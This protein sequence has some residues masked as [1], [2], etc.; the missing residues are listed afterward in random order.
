MNLI[1]H[2]LIFKSLSQKKTSLQKFNLVRVLFLPFLCF[3]FLDVK[4]VAAHVQQSQSSILYTG[5]SGNLTIGDHL[6][7]LE[8]KAGSLGI[9][10]V[11]SSGDFIRSKKNVPNLGVSNSVFWIKFKVHNQSEIENL[12]LE[13]GYPLLDQ[14]HFYSI[15]EEGKYDI[16]KAGEYLPFGS[17]KYNYQTFLFDLKI[18]HGETREYYMQVSSG[19]QIL[20]PA[21][22]GSYQAIAESH[23][24]RDIL[25]GIYFGIILVMMLYN[26]FIYFTVKDKSYLWYVIYIFFVGLT[27]SILQGYAYKYFWPSNPWVAMHSTYLVG[28]AVGLATLMFFRSFL[29]TKENA[30]G[31]HKALHI[32]AV[33]YCLCIVLALFGFY[34]ESYRL[35]DL[36]AG[37]GSLFLLFIA[38][39]IYQ[40]G[41]R[42]A[43][44]FL[45]AWT[46]FLISV[47][48]F[49]LKDMELIPYNLFS[50]YGLQFGSALEVI[51]LS[52]ALAD[53]INVLKKEKEDSQ[54]AA[55]NALKENEKLILEHNLYLEKKVKERTAELQDANEELRVA[56]NHLKDTQSKLVA[57]EKMASLGQLTAGIAHEINNPIN[58][59]SSSVTPLRRD[60]MFLM[61]L[62]E[63]YSVS[64]SQE[65]VKDHFSEAHAFEKRLD[66]P[67]LKE[68]IET[69]LKGIDEGASR[70]T[71]IVKGLRNFSR[72]DESELKSVNFNEGIDST[73]ILLNSKVKNIN[74]V[75]NFG[76]IPDVECYAGKINQ[77]FMNIL[78]NAIEAV[79]EKGDE[80]E[81]VI[82]TCLNPKGEVQVSI[83]DNGTGMPEDVKSKIF[84]PF[85]T[86][87][88]VGEGTGL[89]L[90]IVYRII[91]SHN[92]EIAVNSEEG[93][94]TE[95][96][97]T[98]PKEYVEPVN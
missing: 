25:S 83:K 36:T 30:P 69:I 53:R 76:N 45:I 1:C 89:G 75:R 46:L 12:V 95:F 67:Y 50:V 15:T 11:V 37:T 19:K 9:E 63:K 55:L 20:L 26:L 87:K 13:I 7:I 93:V 32:Y 98:L 97:I 43:K 42:P 84:D 21:V 29:R 79:N 54:A 18:P 23:I 56:L 5:S 8:D 64:S 51:L 73:M 62:L 24:L 70:T 39:K 60:I 94:G 80:G 49:V 48:V 72:L 85:F 27:Q 33:L 77:V 61:S 16:I 17:R 14:I 74:V 58:F 41:Y 38:Y 82:T 40:K 22:I 34:N 96:V 65:S 71:E 91:Q 68:E 88:D 3:F 6:Y 35:V 2:K 4:E 47:S 66:M 28:A 81:I 59:V 57:S 44:F 86:T 31:Y 52:L 78:S 10:D 92:G 90:S